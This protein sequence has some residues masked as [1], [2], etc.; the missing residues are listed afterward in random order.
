MRFTSS[1]KVK[2]SVATISG[3][4]C[5]SAKKRNA[6]VNIIEA[7]VANKLFSRA[8]LCY[9]S[10]ISRGWSQKVC[11]QHCASKMSEPDIHSIRFHTNRFWVKLFLAASPSAITKKGQTS[12]FLWLPQGLARAEPELM[13]VDQSSSS[14]FTPA[15]LQTPAFRPCSSWWPSTLQHYRLPWHKGRS[16]VRQ[17]A[18]LAKWRSSQSQVLRF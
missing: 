16:A 7:A 12:R 17:T 1:Q 5:H 13:V 8:V 11:S 10:P 4:V 14:W 2:R 18:W 6:N 9:T 15:T 3:P